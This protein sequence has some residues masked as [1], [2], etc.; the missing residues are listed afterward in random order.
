MALTVYLFRDEDVMIVAVPAEP[1]SCLTNFNS[2]W[3]VR[4][5][6]KYWEC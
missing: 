6:E 3:Y 5:S 4:L 1:D 2:L